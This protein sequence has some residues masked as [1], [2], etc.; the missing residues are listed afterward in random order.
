MGML[1]LKQGRC[2]LREGE[3]ERTCGFFCPE[4]GDLERAKLFENMDQMLKWLK[5]ETNFQP[6]RL[7]AEYPNAKLVPYTQEA[8][9]LITRLVNR[10]A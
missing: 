8:A 7:K 1:V 4:W 5:E 6:W 2:Y 9:D 10:M 3:K